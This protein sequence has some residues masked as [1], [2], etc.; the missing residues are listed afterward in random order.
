MRLFS[1]LKREPGWLAGAERDDLGAGGRLE[2]FQH[3]LA[4]ELRAGDEPRLHR[5]DGLSRQEHHDQSDP[6]AD[7]VHNVPLSR[8]TRNTTIPPRQ[9]TMTERSKDTRSAMKG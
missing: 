8:A 5:I 4:L 2:Q 6:Q 1:D 9:S 7:K 3:H